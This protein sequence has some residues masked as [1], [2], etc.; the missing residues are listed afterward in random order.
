MNDFPPSWRD[1]LERAE[2]RIAFIRRAR[3]GVVV[4][5]TEGDLVE[6]IEWMNP[7][8]EPEVRSVFFW[9]CRYLK[10][11][12]VALFRELEDINMIHPLKALALQATS[13]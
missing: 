7:D 3:H 13:S 12:R 10:D 8:K 5:T 11:G 6:I 9:K 2:R 4:I 1:D